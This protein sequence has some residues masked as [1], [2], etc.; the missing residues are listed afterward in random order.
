MKT[1]EKCG[2]KK[3][4]VKKRSISSFSGYSKRTVCDDC[5]SKAGVLH[6]SKLAPNTGDVDLEV[7]DLVKITGKKVGK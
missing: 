4:G 7:L 1:C 3:P 2:L 5:A 6:L